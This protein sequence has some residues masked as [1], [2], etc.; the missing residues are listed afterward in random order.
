MPRITISYRRDD[1]GAITGR[2]FDRLVGYYGRESVFRDIDNIPLGVDFRQHINSIL[3][4]SDIVLAIVGPRWIGPRRGQSRLDDAADPVRVEIEVALRKDV[5][6]IPV[7]VLRAMMPQVSQLPESLKDFAYRNGIQV[8][9]DQDFDNHI[10]RLMRAMDQLLEVKAAGPATTLLRA[11]PTSEIDL[12]HGPAEQGEPLAAPPVADPTA[13]ASVARSSR[14]GGGRALLGVVAV[15]TIGAAAAGWYFVMDRQKVPATKDIAPVAA[16]VAPPPTPVAR[17]A[18]PSIDPELLF[19]QTISNSAAQADF[20]EY[21]RKYPEGQFAGLARNRLAAL[22][23]PPPVPTATP[24]PTE[25]VPPA[26]APVVA[27][28][29]PPAAVAPSSPP[30]GEA[31]WTTEEKREVQRALRTLGDY[32]GDADGGFGPGTR[33]AIKQFQSFAGDPDTGTL[34]EDE[35]K[36]LFDMA[37]HLSVLLDQPATSPQ[38]VA[39]S[40]IKGADQ[41]FARGASAEGGKG[42]RQ[43]LAEAAY[44]YALAAADGDAR[45]YANLGT[46]VARGYGTVKPDPV[47]AAALW[48]AAAARGQATAMYN[49][50]IMYERGIGVSANRERARAW[51]ERAAAHGH[52]EAQTALKRL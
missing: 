39:A 10:T 12:S 4:Q 18:P 45:A 28:Q 50:G 47:D 26:A 46:L 31:A 34:T 1:S 13:V 36:R 43:D 6:L 30:E 49:L 3:D 35:R 14:G 20:E 8:D 51:Y 21:L 44:W 16:A 29:P 48:Q 23:A 15:L 24:V 38:G 41:R 9:T 11:G 25:P 52:P 42:A 33:V 5:P 27:V 22:R 2:I 7:L 19:W 37:Q 32:Q 17:T 40:S